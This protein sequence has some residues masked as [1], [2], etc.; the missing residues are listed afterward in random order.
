MTGFKRNVSSKINYLLEHFPVVV[1][2]GVRQAGKT[3]LVKSIRPDWK[4]YDL[5]KPSDYG[6][7]SYH[8]E[9]LFQQ[10]PEHVIFDEAKFFPICH[11][12]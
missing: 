1:I 3:T 5:E 9:F 10:Y 2:L 12:A 11:L 7:V 8:P 6:A 4:Y